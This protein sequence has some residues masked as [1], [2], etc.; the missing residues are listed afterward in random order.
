MD[1][2]E[3]FD[4]YGMTCSNCVL[5]VKKAVEKLEG[6]KEVNV[7]LITNSMNVIKDESLSNAEIIKAVK[8]SGY[9]ASLKGTPKQ[10][11][12]ADKDEQTKNNLIILISS[13]ILLI[14]LF[15]I[16]MGHMLSWPLGSLHHYPLI[17]GLIE[18]VL[19]LSIMII[20]YRFFI[21]GTMSLIKLSPTMDSL[22]SLGS[23]VSFIYSLVLLFIMAY[24]QGNDSLIHLYSMNLCFETAG[25]VPTLI[26][27][28]KTLESYTKGKTTN[29]IKSL[30]DLSPKI[31]HLLDGNKIIDVEVS[32]VEVGQS[33]IVKPG[34]GIPLDG[35][36]IKGTTSIDEKLLTGESIPVDKKED[37]LVYCGTINIQGNITCKV[38]KDSTNTIIAQMIKLVEEASIT[39]TKT[40]EIVDKVS[41]FFVPFIIS[42]SF[43]VF[44][45]WLL[46]GNNFVSS[47]NMDTTALTYAI[48][49]GVSVLVISCPCA[50][51]LATPVAIMVGSGLSAKN[52]ILF[53]NAAS[54]EETGRC[55]YVV[56]DK[57][58]TITKGQPFIQDI[59]TFNATSKDELLSIAYTLENN[60]NH[61]LA[62]SICN[63]AKEK[64]VK[65]LPSKEN[66]EIIGKGIK[67]VI[68]NKTY[69]GGNER[70]IS[71]LKINY[72]KEKKVIEEIILQ[73]KQIILFSDGK[74]LLGLISLADEIKEDSIKSISWLKRQ[75]LV[76]VILSGDN[77]LV[78]KN[79]A[80]KCQIEKYYGEVLPQQ[81]Q[82][83]IASL[84]KE[85]KVIMVGD[86]INDAPSIQKADVGIALNS[87]SD[88]ALD[89]GSVVLTSSSLLGVNYAI[90]ISRQVVKNIKEN[91]F[92]AFFYNLVMIP[93]AAGVFS[94][95]GLNK[96]RPWMGA[97]AMALSS[98]CVSLN[99][100]R[101][102]L[103]NFKN[104]NSNL[105]LKSRDTK[106]EVNES[107]Y[108]PD[109]MC[110]NCVDK[111][112]R[113]LKK[114]KGIKNINVDL[115]TKT[116]FYYNIGVKKNKIVEAINKTGYKV[117]ENVNK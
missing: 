14:P 102:N 60:S 38:T 22:V 26:T 16:S 103:Y 51:G 80:L 90:N 37:D 1:K 89:A 7:N 106:K 20:N 49:R 70:L 107:M 9:K 28:G 62:K 117:E 67:G 73:G 35:K 87:G 4:V 99:A 13:I 93:I 27:I 21:N 17:I 94:S 95:V 91:L 52:G 25:M 30:M 40:S 110:S 74:K 61:P 10:N 45:F 59:L 115:Q 96:L 114:V 98:V 19:S 2:K 43:V 15:Y 5:H 66:N 24:Y 86:G 56:L 104:I 85:G 55:K 47:L 42:V 57:T 82:E 41:F 113:A 83:I 46:L 105:H 44:L 8:L 68:N 48:E 75:G 84:Q 58:G 23:G 111:I 76:P 53:K 97:A 116:A 34:E 29:A 88:I 64:K 100:L 71:D 33:F 81:K 3:S 77:N 31:V 6:I 79:I 50:L 112:T 92:W 65:L 11:S 39:K 78:V 101:L 109:M 108:I 72:S 18:L 54:M 69:Y 12:S 63:Y 32:K 36:I